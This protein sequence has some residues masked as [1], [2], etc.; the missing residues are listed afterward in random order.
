MIS[1]GRSLGDKVV[2]DGAIVTVSSGQVIVEIPFLDPGFARFNGKPIE[3][4]LEPT[5]PDPVSAM[6]TGV[7]TRDDESLLIASAPELAT[8]HVGRNIR[9]VIVDRTAGETTL[10][11]PITALISRPNGTSQV[12][13]RQADGST[14]RVDVV[15]IDQAGGDVSIRP[16]DKDSLNDGDQVRIAPR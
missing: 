6:V 12:E 16:V 4:Y 1:A 8:D 15:V 14:T 2:G 13:A 5:S 11:V 3:L 9:V 7:A 10:L